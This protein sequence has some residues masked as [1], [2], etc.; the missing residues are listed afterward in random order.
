MNIHIKTTTKE[1]K[2]KLNKG[3]LDAIKHQ[4]DLFGVSDMLYHEDKEKGANYQGCEIRIIDLWS[5]TDITKKIKERGGRNITFNQT[6][7]E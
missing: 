6:E 5:D 7:G 3:I 1:Q 4:F 2:E